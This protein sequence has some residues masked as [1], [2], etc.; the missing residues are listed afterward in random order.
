MNLMNAVG[1]ISDEHIAEFAHVTPKKFYV[2]PWMKITAAAASL[3][4]I[5][6]AVPLVKNAVS[7]TSSPE[8]A[9]TGINCS[10]S[11]LNRLG[12]PCVTI[13]ET[14]YIVDVYWKMLDRLP[15]GFEAIGIL[16]GSPEGDVYQWCRGGETVY[17]HPDLKD[18]IYVYTDFMNG[19]DGYRYLHFINEE[20]YEFMSWVAFNGKVYIPV[21]WDSFEQLPSE[22][23]NVGKV[24]GFE[25]EDFGKDGFAVGGDVEIG[26]GIYFNPNSPNEL[27]V[28]APANIQSKSTHIRCVEA[29]EYEPFY[30][31]PRVEVFINNKLYVTNQITLQLPEGYVKIGE[32]ITNRDESVNGYGSVLLNIGDKIYQS[33]DN[34][35]VVYVYTS[36]M[37][38]Y[39]RCVADGA[40]SDDNTSSGYETPSAGNTSFVD[41]MP[42]PLVVINGETY[43]IDN[44]DRIDSFAENLPEGFELI[45]EVMCSGS[46]NKGNDGYGAWFAVGNKIYQHPD[47]PGEVYVNT[48]FLTGGERYWYVRCVNGEMKKQEAK[49]RGG[50]VN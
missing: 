40:L 39:V 8:S 49:E 9:V 46:E 34:S 19:D 5:A 28:D 6:T 7:T 18:E 14:I 42:S 10:A 23:E 41:D 30:A 25:P 17:R 37:D 36:K 29:K 44:G 12:M 31:G 1:K 48:T 4:V 50:S 38:Y 47:K 27:Y 16:S 21:S 33:P 24:I 22:Y 26:S 20:D 43:I 32:V 15:K 35:D 13:N 2:A 3:A 11:A 45:G